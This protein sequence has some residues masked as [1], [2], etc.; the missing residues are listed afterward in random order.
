MPE[1]GRRCKSL[2]KATQRSHRVLLG[3]CNECT[4]SSF[5]LETPPIFPALVHYSGTAQHVTYSIYIIEEVLI[6]FSDF[7]LLM[8]SLQLVHIMDNMQM[9]PD[10]A[11]PNFSLLLCPRH[12]VPGCPGVQLSVYPTS[13]PGARQCP[14]QCH[15]V[16]Q[17]PRQCPVV[18]H[19]L[20]SAPRP[21]SDDLLWCSSTILVPTTQQSTLSSTPIISDV[22]QYSF[23]I[24][25][26]GNY[27]I[28]HPYS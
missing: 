6:L 21:V 10:A 16:P 27:G 14:L 1:V 25:K 22:I 2:N 11:C 20:S 4:K 3:P 24:A 8:Y 28:W 15:G 19:Q 9:S 12:S 17:C 18:H 23:H 5:V 7:K 26:H 13:N